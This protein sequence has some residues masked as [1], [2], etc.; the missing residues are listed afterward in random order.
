[1]TRNKINTTQFV[2]IMTLFIMG[3]SIVTEYNRDSKHDTWLA[4]LLAAVVF[5]PVMLMYAR[6]STLHPDKNLFEIIFFQFGKIGGYIFAVVLTLYFFLLGVIITR[7]FTEFVHVS[8]LQKTPEI[9]MALPL[10]LLC[11][12]LAAKGVQV[13]GRVGFVLFVLSVIIM[14]ATVLLS[15]VN[16]DFINILPVFDVSVS[17]M[18]GSTLFFLSYPFAECIALLCLSGSIK[19]GQS[20]YKAYILGL[21]L[22][23][24]FLLSNSLRTI[25]V[26]GQSAYISSHFPSYIAL[27]TI[28]ISSFIQR[29]E[30]LF[31]GLFLMCVFVKL[32]VC[33]YC[34]SL[35][36]NSMVKI[37]RK[38][39]AAIGTTIVMALIAVAAFK[40]VIEL[41][42]FCTRVQMWLALPVQVLVPMSVWIKSEMRRRR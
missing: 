29:I 7:T 6:I 8:A 38:N 33:V 36:L 21:I 18:A 3:T 22:G 13:I 40:N 20:K 25:L 39:M 24:V 34:I 23:A 1:M 41:S 9:L 16:V 14:L 35:G 28:Q 27:G 10:C 30:S 5:V 11:S 31:S 42:N 15:I 19:D 17:K 4:M 37:K 32:A 12:I 26:L 2:C